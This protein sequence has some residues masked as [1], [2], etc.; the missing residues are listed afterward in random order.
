[1]AHEVPDLTP[2][3]I[4]GVDYYTVKQFAWITNRTDQSVRR[5]ILKGNKI[6]RLEA[7]YFGGKPFIPVME[8]KEF[9]FTFAGTSPD[10]YRYTDAGG[11]VLVESK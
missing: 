2:I 9:P 3:K 11:T 10:T 7:K 6:R 4:N 5:L 1:M 8:F